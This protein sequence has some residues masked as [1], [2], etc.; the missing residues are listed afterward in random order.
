MKQ[1]SNSEISQSWSFQRFTEFMLIQHQS[2]EDRVLWH[3]HRH[4]EYSVK[5]GCHLGMQLMHLACECD[6]SSSGLLY[7]GVCMG[8]IC[9]FHS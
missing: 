6:E 3:F 2:C 8:I 7:V 9:T 4:G 1:S 5:S